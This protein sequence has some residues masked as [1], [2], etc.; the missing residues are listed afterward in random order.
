M[1][2]SLEHASQ[3]PFSNAILFYA[4]QKDIPLLPVELF[5]SIPGRGVKGLINGKQIFVGS[6][7]MAEEE[8]MALPE[9]AQRLSKHEGQTI[10][11]VWSP[12]GVIGYITLSDQ[13]R[14]S[15]LRAIRHLQAMN[16]HPVMLTGDQPVAAKE[17]AIALGITDF[18]AR[19]LPEDKLREVIRWQGLKEYVGM[20]G[21][22]INDAPALAKANVGFAIGAGSDIA[23]ESSDVTLMRSDLLGVVTS[24]ELSKATLRKIRQNLFLAFFYNVLAIPLAAA[25]LLTPVIAAAAMALS[26]VSVITNALLLRRWQPGE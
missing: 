10:C 19:A 13:I 22:G 23:I 9:I 11:V 2:A 12:Q 20:V 6:L 21:D 18:T 17:V 4:K 5:E 26:S 1:A 3:H 7:S 25:G 8:G 14:K 24:I 16:I 15:S